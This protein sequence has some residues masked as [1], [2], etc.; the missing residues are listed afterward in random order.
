MLVLVKASVEIQTPGIL[1][2]RM[3][4]PS[5]SMDVYLGLHRY[6]C[7]LPTT[8]CRAKITHPCYSPKEPLFHAYDCETPRFFPINEILLSGLTSYS[9]LHGPSVFPSLANLGHIYIQLS[10]SMLPAANP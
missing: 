10:I 6:Y 9:Q 8:R 1:E 7:Y 2:T 5:D 3:L 4:C